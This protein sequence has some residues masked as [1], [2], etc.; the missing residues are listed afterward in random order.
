MKHNIALIVGHYGPGTGCSTNGRDEWALAQKDVELLYSELLREQLVRPLMFNIDHRELR[1]KILGDL[2]TTR[3]QIAIKA[4]WAS[5]VQAI[6][7]IEFH[8]NSADI[9]AVEGNLIVAP[10]MSQFAQFMDRALATLPNRHRDPIINSKFY[11]FQFMQDIPTIILEPAF[12]FEDAIEQDDWRPMLVS[13]VKH[14][15]YDY[16]GLES[17]S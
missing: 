17:Y 6:V 1:W 10:M 16:F 3:N 8:Y 12:I 2:L 4:N 15:I 14:G 9:A 7:A 5:A 11:F 13:A